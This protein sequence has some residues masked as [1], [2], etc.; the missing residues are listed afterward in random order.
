MS[1]AGHSNTNLSR[2]GA[3][4]YFDWHYFDKVIRHLLC[5]LITP[6]LK[7]NTNRGEK[8]HRVLWIVKFPIK[9]VFMS[10]VNSLVLHTMSFR[11]SRRTALLCEVLL[12]AVRMPTR[13]HTRS[14]ADA[15][16]RTGA[17]CPP[18]PRSVSRAS[19]LSPAPSWSQFYSAH[20]VSFNFIYYFF[21]VHLSVIA[22]FLTGHLLRI[23]NC[24]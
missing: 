24:V 8:N 5:R 3:K 10:L 13:S 21:N 14:A 22:I 16:L 9:T 23:P 18:R 1:K 6:K 15:E 19:R 2:A 11:P 7:A 12:P 17:L 4:K 20:S